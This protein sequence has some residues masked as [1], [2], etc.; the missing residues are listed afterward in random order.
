MVSVPV[1]GA[2]VFAAIT[3]VTVPLFV[4]LLPP[5]TVIQL[6]LLTAVHEH[7]ADVATLVVRVAPAAATLTELDDNVKLQLP[8]CVTVTV[9]PATV[10]VAVRVPATVFARTV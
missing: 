8:L 4:P 2:P 5:V 6:T 9:C 3:N 10:S 7:P 1:R